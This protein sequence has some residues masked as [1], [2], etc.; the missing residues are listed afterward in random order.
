[1]DRAILLGNTPAVHY[2]QTKQ[3]HHLCLCRL[4]HRIWE[5]KVGKQG[6]WEFYTWLLGTKT[7]S[8]CEV[9]IKDMQLYLHRNVVLILRKLWLGL[10]C[11]GNYCH[12]KSMQGSGA[13]R[14]SH[15][16]SEGF[17]S[18]SS[19]NTHSS[20]P[21]GG[22]LK[23]FGGLRDLVP[24]RGIWITHLKEH[25]HSALLARTNHGDWR[26]IRLTQR[27]GVVTHSN[28]P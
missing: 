23:P 7:Y 22:I 26:W 5:N 21:C 18:P 1:M 9:F 13:L 24:Q 16:G 11:Q 10:Y 17:C 25:R 12:F 14:G 8:V 27:A 2:L 6:S 28:V 4:R 20:Q 15:G 3:I 19:K